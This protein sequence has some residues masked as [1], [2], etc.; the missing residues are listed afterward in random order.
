MKELTIDFTKYESLEEFH[1]DIA[2]TF[3]FPAHY[4]KNLDALQDMIEELPLQEWHFQ[5]I[6]GGKIPRKKQMIIHNILMDTRE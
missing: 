6:Y 2:K 4:G 3:G 1:E 5:F